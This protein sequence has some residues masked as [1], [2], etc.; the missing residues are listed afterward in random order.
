LQIHAMQYGGIAITA[1][2]VVDLE[3]GLRAHGLSPK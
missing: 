1:S 2:Q 3:H